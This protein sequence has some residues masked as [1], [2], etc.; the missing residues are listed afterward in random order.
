M[1]CLNSKIS[2]KETKRVFE[3]TEN[4]TQVSRKAFVQCV[5]ENKIVT[6]DINHKTKLSTKT[7]A[8]KKSST[9]TLFIKQKYQPRD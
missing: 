4:L 7:L 8:L 5:V 9:K 3:K 1:S 2:R 6:Q